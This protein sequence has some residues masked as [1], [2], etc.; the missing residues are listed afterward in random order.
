MRAYLRSCA[1]LPAG[2]RRFLLSEPLL[3]L[4][5]GLIA[6]VLNLHLLALGLDEATIGRITSL[7]TLVMGAASLPAIG[8]CRRWGRRAVLIV[9]LALMSGGTAATA[10]ARELLP[11]ALAQAVY[12]IGLAFLLTAEI[13]LLYAYCADSRARLRAFSMMFVAFTPFTALGTYL[14][15]ALTGALPG[16]TPYQAA[17]WGA[18]GALA[19]CT[20]TRFLLLPADPHR[21]EG[22]ENGIFRSFPPSRSVWAFTGFAALG[23]LSYALVTPFANL[24][25]SAA[26]GWN[27]A[28]TAAL[29]A[30]HAVAT[31]LFSL[32]APSLIERWGTRRTATGLFVLNTALSAMLAIALPAPVFVL[33]FLL[34]GGLFTLLANVTDGQI[35]QAVPD[36]KRDLVAGLRNI[37]RNFGASAGAWAT[38][39]ALSDKMATAPFAMAAA[40]TLITWIYFVRTC[41]PLLAEWERVSF[42]R[43]TPAHQRP[44]SAAPDSGCASRRRT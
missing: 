1:S 18:A 36:A 3:G 4:G 26:L 32:L 35:L 39:E 10:A 8:L 9:G 44:R 38:G 24:I 2:V 25:V 7:S 20:L 27:D 16:S 40:A 6:M 29:L 13:P 34:R 30:V 28:D 17:L 5:F 21:D 19:L 41:W 37:A 42:A 33:L 11:I 12:G 15:G 22:D 23:G 14:G 43:V 31:S